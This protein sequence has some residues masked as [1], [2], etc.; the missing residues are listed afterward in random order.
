MYT[1]KCPACNKNS[2]SSSDK[3]QWICPYCEKDITEVL[4]TIWKD[5]KYNKGENKNKNCC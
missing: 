3:N 4:T 1:K 2:F 5:N